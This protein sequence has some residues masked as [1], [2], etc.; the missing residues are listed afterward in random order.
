LSKIEAANLAALVRG[1][2]GILR[3]EILDVCPYGV[4][5]FH[6]GDNLVNRGG[7]PGFWEVY[8]RTDFTGFIIQRLTREL[9]GGRV[10]RRGLVPT[11]WTY[12]LNRR[13]LF[14]T[15][16]PQLRHTF[17]LLFSDK[18]PP[19]HEQ[20]PYSYR[21]FRI[22]SLFQQFL[23]L[24]KTSKSL[25]CKGLFK[26][27]GMRY[28]WRLSYLYCDGWRNAVLWKAREIKNPKGRFLADPM[29]FEKD[30]THYCFVE[31]YN[32]QTKRGC[33]SV[34]KFADRGYDFLGPVLKE[35]F[36]L[37]YPFIFE[38]DGVVYM[39]PESSESNSVRLYRCL[40][41]P[42][43]WELAEIL[44]PDV[45]FVDIN[46]FWRDDRWWLIAT[47]L[48]GDVG[49]PSTNLVIYYS[50]D[51]RHGTWHPHAKNP[52]ICDAGVGRNAGMV[53]EEGGSLRVSQSQGFDFYGK[54]VGFG[55]IIKLDPDEFQYNLKHRVTADFRKDALG[56]HTFSYR[57]GL[58]VFDWVKREHI[59]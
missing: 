5:S 13:K 31:D 53:F 52:V 17:E 28:R 46:I 50:S 35:D 6:H 9:D 37:S 7:P 18:E 19:F 23:Y 39:C 27:S 4:I 55:E 12:T 14:A 33:I 49:D 42:T 29:V 41:F 2:A 11:S 25:I 10:I 58:L 56:I 20:H 30:Q 8:Y 1:G 21:L 16:T 59:V 47:D 43:R 40:E 57:G 54:S 44:I 38:A 22:P 34:I 51:L 24:C 48:C 36:H 3:G 45:R 32:Y 26:A 15:A